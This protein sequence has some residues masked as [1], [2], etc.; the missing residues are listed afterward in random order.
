MCIR[1]RFLGEPPISTALF[2]DIG[3]Y[4]VIVG[5]I[6]SIALSLEERYVD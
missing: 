2:F 4:L 1:D 6:S 5:S 3:V